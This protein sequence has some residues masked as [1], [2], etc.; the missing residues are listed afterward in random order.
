MS[1]QIVLLTAAGAGIGALLGKLKSCPDGGCPLTA[2]PKR[3]AIWGGILG[4]F[5]AMSAGQGILAEPGGPAE[6]GDVWR[7]A[8]TEEEFQREVLDQPGVAVVYFHADWCGA[9]RQY[10]PTLN[11]VSRETAD[12]ARYVKVDADAAQALARRYR[13]EALPTTLFFSGGE[14]QGRLVGGVPEDILHGALAKA[15]QAGPKQIGPA[16]ENVNVQ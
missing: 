7:E 6:A 16:E 13:I 12:R 3:G 14:V 2:N 9:C 8:A 11:K 10:A 1:M 5:I 15:A 4:L